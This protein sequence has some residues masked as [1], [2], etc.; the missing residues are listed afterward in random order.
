MAEQPGS[1]PRVIAVT[2]GKGGVGKSSIAV[3][4]ALALVKGGARVCILDADTGLANVNILLGIE[5]EYRLEHVLYGARSIEEVIVEGPLGLQVIPGASGI[6]ECVNLQRRQQLRLTRELERIESGL[7]YLLIDTAAGIGQTTMDFIAAAHQ[8][9]LVITP[10]PTSLTDAFSLLKLVV[11]RQRRCSVQVVVNMTSSAREARQIFHRFSAAVDK[12]IGVQVQ[13]LG[14]VQR[15]ESLRAAVLLQSP[16]ALYPDSDPSSRSFLRLA[17][18]LQ[19]SLPD[20][21]QSSFSSYWQRRYRSRAAPATAP[22]DPAQKLQRWVRQWQQLQRQEGLT[23]GQLAQ[24]LNACHDAY[25]E[26]HGHPALDAEALAARLGQDPDRHGEWLAALT[27]ALV[28]VLTSL[29]SSPPL[30]VPGQAAE[31]GDDPPPAPS[32]PPCPERLET[33][34]PRVE[35]TSRHGYDEPRFGSQ[36]SLQELLQRHGEQ[37]RSLIELIKSLVP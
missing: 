33:S 30:A 22:L 36:A 11:R 31:L 10:E 17:E 19:Q 27:S 28:P 26:N 25:W 4:L 15:D 37:D 14:I 34:R 29:E 8:T 21:I 5:P 16:V 2:S 24:A 12:Y 35:P 3:N 32:P 1:S 20:V 13:L 7:D 18:A 6:G 23:P 9:L